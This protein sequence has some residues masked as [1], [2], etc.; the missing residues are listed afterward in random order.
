MPGQTKNTEEMIAEDSDLLEMSYSKLNLTYPQFTKIKVGDY[1]AYIGGVLSPWSKPNTA[2]NRDNG[3]LSEKNTDADAF[4]AFKLD[5]MK[6]YKDSA[7]KIHLSIHPADLDKAWDLLYPMLL[8]QRVPCFKTARINAAQ[9]LLHE[10]SQVDEQ[11]LSD[12][13]LTRQKKELAMRDILRVSNGMQITIYIPEGKEQEYNKILAAIEPRLYKA[14]V[15]PGIIDQSDRTLGI[16]SSVRHVG[17]EYTTHEKVSGYKSIGVKDPFI[18][19]KSLQDEIQIKWYGLAYE[20]H[21]E[22]IQIAL[23]QV[24]DAELK[25]KNGVHTKKEFAQV[26]DVAMEY[27]ERWHELL[28]Q[29]KNLTALSAKDKQ[30]FDN[31]KKWIDDGYRLIP[32]LRKHDNKKIKEAEDALLSSLKIN[33]TP[34][35]P[36]RQLRR[37]NARFGLNKRLTPVADMEQKGNTKPLALVEQEIPSAT[38]LQE[39]FLHRK[40]SFKELQTG[41]LSQIS[42]LIIEQEPTNNTSTTSREPSVIEETPHYHSYLWKLLGGL[43]GLCLG[44]VV[45]LCLIPWT[46]GVSLIVLPL[47]GTVT[48]G[49]IGWGTESLFVKH[50]AEHEKEQPIANPAPQ[51]RREDESGLEQQLSASRGVRKLRMFDEEKQPLLADKEVEQQVAHQSIAP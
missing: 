32:T 48:G 31:F 15:R 36:F 39:L 22:K 9:R 27:F 44:L 8:E 3:Q 29:A 17:D 45:D 2:E 4:A 13:G 35:T 46:L 23:Q 40:K 18:P 34:L 47:L 7:W 5:K 42:P 49:L 50:P 21:I 1:V 37:Q 12:H 16:Y 38:V 43:L 14:G 30:G 24:I 10:I 26:C 6:G 33:S 25:Y 41:H 20:R 28:K 19:V 51:N 11:F